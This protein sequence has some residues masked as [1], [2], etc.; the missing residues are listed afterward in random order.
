[1]TL[2]EYYS[3]L[4]E[5]LD[6]EELETFHLAQITNIGFNSDPKKLGRKWK[7]STP[8][9]AGTAKIS[10]SDVAK[11]IVAFAISMGGDPSRGGNVEEYARATG[12]IVAYQ[13]PSGGLFDKKG[14]SVEKTDNTL[15]VKMPEEM[16]KH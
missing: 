12:R 16:V 1:M 9:K 10:P 3:L 4:A 8:D 2:W 7:W 6:A 13:H 11:S 5:S 15:I 14:R